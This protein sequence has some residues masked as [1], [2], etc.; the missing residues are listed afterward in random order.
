MSWA[1]R[2]ALLPL[3]LLSTTPARAEFPAAFSAWVGP[4]IGSGHREEVRES[5]PFSVLGAE[6]AWRFAPGRALVAVYE[7]AGG[8]I[9]VSY[10]PESPHLDRLEHF[11]ITLGPEFSSPRKSAVA[12]FCRGSIGAGRV[13][14]AGFRGMQIYT[15]PTVPGFEPLTEAGFAWSG[16]AGLWLVPRPGPVGLAI[17]I[18]AAGTSARHSSCQSM[19]ATLGIAL[20]PLDRP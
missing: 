13:T 4:G 7:G 2:A 3:I 6:A 12:F 18:H 8:P 1:A 17:A 5:G 10:I 20:C 16:A 14:T 9:G 11:A 19:G 15:D